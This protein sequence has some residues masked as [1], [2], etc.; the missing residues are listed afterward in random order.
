[1]PLLLLRRR[2]QRLRLLRRLLLLLLFRPTR[3]LWRDRVRWCH[4]WQWRGQDPAGGANFSWRRRRRR[5]QRAGVH[6]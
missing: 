4:R 2:R 5:R 1:M 6:P 3:C